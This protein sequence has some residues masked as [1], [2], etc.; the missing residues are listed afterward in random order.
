MRL[1]LAPRPDQAVYAQDLFV[2]E[3]NLCYDFTLL[4]KDSAFY[5]TPSEDVELVVSHNP[6]EPADSRFI[7][8]T[9][10]NT[11]VIVHVHYQWDYFTIEQKSSL[12]QSLSRSTAAIVP[13]DFIRD[14][15]AARFPGVAWHTVRNGVRR[16]LYFPSTLRE[17]Q[18]FRKQTGIPLAKKLIG[19]VGRLT[20]AK[21]LIL[22]DYVCENSSKI[23]SCTFVQFPYWHLENQENYLQH[24]KQMKAHDPRHVFYFPDKGPRLPDRPMRYF[25]VLL[26]PSFSELQPMVVLEAL[27]SGVPVVAT[28]CSPFLNELQSIVSRENLKIVE[29]PSRFKMGATRNFSFEEN[30][31]HAMSE[32]LLE[33]LDKSNVN[34]DGERHN[35]SREIDIAGFSA[36][37]MYMK[38]MAIYEHVLKSFRD[39]VALSK[40]TRRAD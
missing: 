11:A 26:M 38:Y 12:T 35:L 21:G 8:H 32:T 20:P 3:L 13:A 19:Y 31:L 39:D 29:L 37:K 23:N 16:N 6:H 28:S 5:S 14:D 1:V 24:A 7:Q 4:R 10:Q 2:V 15:L 9:H 18:Q 27:A 25:D 40:G 17:R 36:T 33:M 22:L 30:E 34:D